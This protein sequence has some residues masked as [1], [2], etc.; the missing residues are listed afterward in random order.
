VSKILEK[1]LHDLQHCAVDAD[2][3]IL[4]SQYM[5]MKKVERKIADELGI[6]ILR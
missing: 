6:V 1:L 4:Q 3:E 5:F 2:I